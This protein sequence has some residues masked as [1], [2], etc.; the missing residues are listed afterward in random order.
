M[1]KM[2]PSPF[3]PSPFHT[4]KNSITFQSAAS[5]ALFLSIFI[6]NSNATYSV[7]EDNGTFT[8]TFTGGY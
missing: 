2:P 3:D 5:L 1:L 8:L 6:P 4:M 7:R